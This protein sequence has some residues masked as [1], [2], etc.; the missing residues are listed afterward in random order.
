MK[1][2]LVTVT[3]VDLTIEIDN[4]SPNQR[5]PNQSTPKSIYLD[6]ESE[7]RSDSDLKRE[8]LH[9]PKQSNL[10]REENQHSKF[11]TSKV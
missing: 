1:W 4:R 7:I 9:L 8:V 2:I 6:A 11:V 5:T 3:D 10:K